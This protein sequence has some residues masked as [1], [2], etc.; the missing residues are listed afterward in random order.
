MEFSIIYN[1]RDLLGLDCNQQFHIIW[2]LLVFLFRGGLTI[3]VTVTVTLD[4][5][6]CNMANLHYIYHI[7]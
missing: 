5:D 1:S 2:P 6:P 7:F 4:V 3:H